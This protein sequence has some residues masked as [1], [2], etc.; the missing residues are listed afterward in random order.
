MLERFYQGD[1]SRSGDAGMGLGLHIVKTLTERHG[2]RVVVGNRPEGGARVYLTIPAS[3][4]EARRA[5]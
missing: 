5:E 4:P 2:G 1:P 3:P